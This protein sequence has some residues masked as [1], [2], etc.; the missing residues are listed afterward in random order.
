M[1]K[2]FLVIE[3]IWWGALP[4][5]HNREE[6]YESLKAKLR[7]NQGDWL[8]FQGTSSVSR[9]NRNLCYRERLWVPNS[10]PLRTR[11]I[12]TSHDSVLTGHPGREGLLAILRR[13]YFWPGMDEQVRRFTR[14]CK[15]CGRNTV[16]RERRKGLLRPLPIPEQQWQE[17]SMDYITDLPESNGYT[18]ILVITDRLG[19]GVIFAPCKDLSAKTLSDTFINEVFKHHGLPRAITSDRGSQLIKGLWQQVCKRLEIEQ[20]I[21]TAYH[22]ET[23]GATERAN[24]VLEEYLR[25]FTSYFQEDWV[26]WLPLAQIAVNSRDAASTGVSPFF[27]SHGYNPRLGDGIDLGPLTSVRHQRNPRETGDAIV[28]KLRQVTELAQTMMAAAQQRQ[29]DI[30]NRK[31]DPAPSFRVGDKVWLDLRNF[32]TDRPCRKLADK[33]AQF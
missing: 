6:P 21:S 10:E 17:L 25:H 15:S 3:T 4:L 11:L 20:R 31:R 22:P 12:Q 8:W 9:S 30:A 13:K 19:K 1:N 28:R 16:W 18:N 14:N 33:H 23:D 32:K 29:E 27:L 2:I 26:Y 7:G 5:S 24:Q